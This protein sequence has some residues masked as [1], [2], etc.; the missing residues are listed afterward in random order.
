MI[1]RTF[2]VARELASHLRLKPCVRFIV[3]SF[4]HRGAGTGFSSEIETAKIRDKPGPQ[5]TVARELA[6]HLR[7]KL[8]RRARI[9]PRAPCGA[10]TGFSSE[11]ETLARVI[12]VVARTKW[13]GN[14]LLI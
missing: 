12:L 3:N 13:R 1:Y 8:A 14:W 9:P 5:G 2:Q 6:S 4:L 7:L 10:G 11:I